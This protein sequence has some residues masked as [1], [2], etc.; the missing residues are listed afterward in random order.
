MQIQPDLNANSVVIQQ[1]MGYMVNLFTKTAAIVAIDGGITAKDFQFDP[2]YT[3]GYKV[4]GP[5]RS[6]A[7]NY[8]CFKIFFTS[9]VENKD[10]SHVD[11]FF[12]D[13][14][15]T[16]LHIRDEKAVEKLVQ[17]FNLG[18]Q[19]LSKKQRIFLDWL[20]FQVQGVCRKTRI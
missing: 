20:D 11:V 16:H 2:K 7:E 8:I 18:V 13:E 10:V 5:D 14:G 15:R 17:N 1:S 12:T 3:Q 19:S 4:F 6:C 9:N